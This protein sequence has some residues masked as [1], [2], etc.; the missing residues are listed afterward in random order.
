MPLRA[1]KLRK[2][3]PGNAERDFLCVR[4]FDLKNTVTAYNMQKCVCCY[5]VLLQYLSEKQGDFNSI[6]FVCCKEVDL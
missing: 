2:T 3:P 1:G 6:L 4:H 5:F